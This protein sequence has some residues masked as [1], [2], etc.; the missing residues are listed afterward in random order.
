VDAGTRGARRV[1]RLR[2]VVAVGLVLW[3]LA[4][5][6]ILGAAVL[7]IARNGAQAPIYVLAAVW[8][9]VVAGV[10]G[11]LTGRMPDG[12]ASPPWAYRR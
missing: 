3:L 9:A 10:L 2:P 11:W 12:P 7:V 6:G 5:A 1:A 8:V 4:A